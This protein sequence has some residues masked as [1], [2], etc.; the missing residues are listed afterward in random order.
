ML[1]IIIPGEPTAQGRP[2]FTTISG[3]AVAYDPPKSKNYK[4][5]VKNLTRQAIIQQGWKFTDLP[6]KVDVIAC[7]GIPKSKSRKFREGAL[8]GKILPAKKPDADNLF[9]TVTDAMSGIAY[10]DDKQI[11]VTTICKIYSDE[12][13]VVVKIELLGADGQ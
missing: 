10:A 2:R 12:P 1:K 9:K 5:F 3:H 13:K 11:C 6:I 4:A 8:S 7:L